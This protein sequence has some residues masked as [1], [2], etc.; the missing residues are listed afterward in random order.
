[1]SIFILAGLAG[2]KQFDVMQPEVKP[3]VYFVNAKN[4]YSNNDQKV[5]FKYLGIDAKA[6]LLTVGVCLMGDATDV[7]RR[8]PVRQGVLPEE[9]A[10]DEPIAFPDEVDDLSRAAAFGGDIRAHYVSFSHPHI[11][12]FIQDPQY[13]LL[14]Q[15]VDLNLTNV[16]FVDPTKPYHE[17]GTPLR[18]PVIVLRDPSLDP[19]YLQAHYPEEYP[20]IPPGMESYYWVMHP[21]R[22]RLELYADENFSIRQQPAPPAAARNLNLFYNITVDDVYSQPD[23]WPRPSGLPAPT[24]QYWEFYFK[25]WSA[26]KMEII[27]RANGAF[28]N[29][30]LENPKREFPDRDEFRYMFQNTLKLI[31]AI[32]ANP[33]AQGP[34]QKYIYEWIWPYLVYATDAEGNP[35]DQVLHIVDERGRQITF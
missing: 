17:F 16:A 12:D 3:E 15:A 28:T 25:D 7:D 22:L 20:V 23:N 21:K 5:A 34:D 6:K 35:T 9:Y 2:C 11:M 19:M 13:G 4:S 30:E 26:T 18:Y 24:P 33:K 1:M 31:D 8:V 10:M 27:S 32:I 29:W 14:T